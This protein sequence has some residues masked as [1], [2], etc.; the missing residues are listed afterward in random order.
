[1]RPF[2]TNITMQFKNNDLH[3]AT[4]DKVAK[5]TVNLYGR[6]TSLTRRSVNWFEDTVGMRSSRGNAAASDERLADLLQ[7]D[8]ACSGYLPAEHRGEGHGWQYR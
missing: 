6:I 1:M 4:K 5:A 8:S 7:V 2:Y 3:Y